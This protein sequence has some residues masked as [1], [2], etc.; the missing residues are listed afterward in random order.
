M[1]ESLMRAL[2]IR[3]IYGASTS[4]G[5]SCGHA[6]A[7]IQCMWKKVVALLMA[8]AASRAA[9]LPTGQIVDGVRAP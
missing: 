6:R 8:A 9:D 3:P 5:R 2:W 7:M 1:I 4:E